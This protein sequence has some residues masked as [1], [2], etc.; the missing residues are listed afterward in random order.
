MRNYFFLD[1]NTSQGL[2]FNKHVKFFLKNKSQILSKKKDT[3]FV[4]D[5]IL[6]YQDWADINKKSLIIANNLRKKS[7][8]IHEILEEDTNKDT[9]LEILKYLY[10]DFI[11]NKIKN[12]YKLKDIYICGLFKN[13][14]LIKFLKKKKII[15][16]E[17][18][19]SKFYLL[20]SFIFNALER[21]Y[22]IFKI[23]ILPEYI[24]FLTKKD[25][26]KKKYFC[27]FN[28]FDEKIKTKKNSYNFT[29][30]KK[31]LN[32]RS[33]LIVDVNIRDNLSKSDAIINDVLYMKNIFKNISL[34]SYLKKFYL[35]FFIYRFKLIFFGF[36]SKILYRHFLSKTA[37][38]VFFSVYSIEKF[39]SAMLPTSITTQR[40]QKKGSKETIFLYESTTPNLSRIE[41]HKNIIDQVQY[42]HMSYT[43]LVAN[44]ISI[45]YLL[46]NSN[47]FQ[48]FKDFGNVISDLS[49]RN[50]AN[51][52]LIKN[53]LNIK[54]DRK[55]IAIFDNSTGLKGVLNKHE[56]IK[57]LNYINIL[58]NKYKK[59][60][61][62]M[63]PK[64][65]K[66]N[67][68]QD[69]K[70]IKSIFKVLEKKNNFKCLVSELTNYQLLAISDIIISQPISSLIYESL[71]LKKITLIY[72]NRPYFK[73][74]DNL[75]AKINDNIN[76]LRL[77]YKS[78]IF[79]S[80]FSNSLRTRSRFA[81]KLILGKK[82][83]SYISELTN[84]L[85][86]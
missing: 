75:Y 59:F 9:A 80:K 2:W 78:N 28:I 3:I 77:K 26:S 49:E 17:F 56:Y 33:I 43:T 1:N 64:Q 47:K 54:Y 34:V 69:D 73:N 72:D 19:I 82:K 55:I 36:N 65:P 74:N 24:F 46:K 76:I 5:D 71:F 8:K 29:K 63:L 67:I 31:Y 45:K 27:A 50:L 30:I 37:W 18:K 39:I 14:S 20:Y 21:V 60:Y 35:K 40:M 84:Y 51:K 61:F 6:N 32:K 38:E 23:F 70:S 48:K 62:L 44:K 85:N 68:I 12:Y 10:A 13:T 57:F 25:I 86:S 42:S 79:D 16:Q 83:Y 66:K 4:D 58:V 81:S 15:S 41:N 7:S 53:K 22:F 52:K 11:A